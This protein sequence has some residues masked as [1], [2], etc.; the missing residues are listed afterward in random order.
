[1]AVHLEGV[2]S[3]FTPKTKRR[4]EKGEATATSLNRNTPKQ[5]VSC[6]ASRCTTPSVLGRRIPAQCLRCNARTLSSRGPANAPL[7]VLGKPGP[8]R[9]GPTPLPNPTVSSTPCFRDSPAPLAPKCLLS[10]QPLQPDPPILLP[11]QRGR[12]CRTGLPRRRRGR[13]PSGPAPATPLAA[14]T[15]DAP[16]T[17]PL[18]AASRSPRRPAPRPSPRRYSHFSLPLELRFLLLLLPLLLLVQAAALAHRAPEDVDAVGR[19]RRALPVPLAPGHGR[20]GGARARARLPPPVP[21]TFPGFGALPHA[22][23]V[24]RPRPRPA[25]LLVVFAALGVFGAGRAAAPRPAHPS[26]RSC[27]QPLA[28]GPAR[29][30]LP[31]PSPPDSGWSSCG[32]RGE[33]SCYPDDFVPLPEVNGRHEGRLK[34]QGRNAR[35]C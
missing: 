19:G 16:T 3:V 34:R 35:S 6:G 7:H 25:P 27:D 10:S 2:H 30:R 22:L 12:P 31:S 18:P 26:G 1:M 32:D 33:G 17:T 8:H 23:L 15:P 24:P 28:S 14:S 20:V 13:W 9:P 29:A 11:S 5:K 21:F 4:P